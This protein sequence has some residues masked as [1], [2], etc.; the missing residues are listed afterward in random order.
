MKKET[1]TMKINDDEF[2]IAARDAYHA[3]RATAPRTVEEGE[4]FS[5]WI[6]LA[7]N[8]TPLERLII[9]ASWRDDARWQS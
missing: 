2:M 6:H 5:K 3:F 1:Q 9:R 4:A 7:K 8:L